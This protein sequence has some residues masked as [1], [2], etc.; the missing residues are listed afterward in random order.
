MKTRRI[1]KWLWIVLPV[2]VVGGV[3][4]TLKQEQEITCKGVTILTERDGSNYFLSESDIHQFLFPQG[5]KATGK[6]PSTIDVSKLEKRLMQ[7]PYIASAEA[8]FTPQGMLKIRVIQ[9]VPVARIFD[10]TGKSVFLSSEGVLMPADRGAGRRVTVVS[11][12]IPDT[13]SKYEGMKVDSLRRIPVLQEIFKTAL[14]LQQDSL[15][16][17]LTGQIYVNPSQELELVSTLDDHTILIGNADS[18]AYKF[19]K[20]FVFYRKGLSRTGWDVYSSINLKHSNQVI[21]TTK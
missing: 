14:Y 9:R 6:K 16:R 21:C 1:I 3:L 19:H 17:M 13:L 2:L 7:H 12:W 20:L 11:G 5:D 10:N 8:Y 15:S 18:L 4:L